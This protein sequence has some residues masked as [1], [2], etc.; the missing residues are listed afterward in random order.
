[1]LLSFNIE[2]FA[3]AFGIVK[4]LTHVALLDSALFHKLCDLVADLEVCRFEVHFLYLRTVLYVLW[5]FPIFI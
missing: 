3:G 5:A 1:M 4:D 2:L